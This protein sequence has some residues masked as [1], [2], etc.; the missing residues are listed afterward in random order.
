MS[1]DDDDH[2]R[3]A[4]ETWSRAM[5]TTSAELHQAIVSMRR[6][7]FDCFAEEALRQIEIK[8]RGSAA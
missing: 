1:D 4:F 8:H 6:C 2:I 7:P 3:A 5:T